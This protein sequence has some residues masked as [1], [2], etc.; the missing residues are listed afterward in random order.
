MLDQSA[1]IPRVDS[2]RGNNVKGHTL[3][4]RGEQELGTRNFK[5]IQWLGHPP[6]RAS[7]ISQLRALLGARQKDVWSQTKFVEKLHY[8][9]RN[10][11]KR[12]LAAHPKDWPWGSFRFYAKK[13]SGLVRIDP[14]R[15]GET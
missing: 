10:P 1:S 15:C 7:T 6:S 9:H 11:V 12:K 5:I 2:V 3:V 14:L 8:R 13:E 4:R